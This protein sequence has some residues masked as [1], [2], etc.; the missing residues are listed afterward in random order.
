MT[1]DREKYSGK[2]QMFHT[3]LLVLASCVPF[4]PGISDEFVFDDLPAVKNNKDI[5]NPDPFIILQHDFWGD[6]ITWRHSHKSYRPVTSLTYWAQRRLAGAGP[7]GLKVVNILLHS[8][9]TLLLNRLLLS[10]RR[11]LD[12]AAPAP[13]LLTSVM[14]ACH[15]VHVEPVLSVVGR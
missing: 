14:F 10:A 7:G 8:L 6:N 5:M 2:T 12:L 9:N 4:I 3:T 13:A 11:G 1:D 15:P